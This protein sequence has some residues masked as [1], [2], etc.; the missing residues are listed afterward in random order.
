MIDKTSRNLRVTPL[1]RLNGILASRMAS[2]ILTLLL[3]FPSTPGYTQT[4]GKKTPVRQGGIDHSAAGTAGGDFEE[5]PY[6][7]SI[8]RMDTSGIV[9]DGLF[10]GPRVWRRRKARSSRDDCSGIL[11][12]ADRSYGG[13][14]EAIPDGGWRPHAR[15]SALQQ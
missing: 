4:T 7:R 12:G 13:G 10:S 3:I 6:G 1:M 5:E 11:A 2:G 15:A 14:L 8:V 9:Y